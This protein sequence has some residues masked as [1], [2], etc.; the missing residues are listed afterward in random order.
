M[1]GSQ[2]NSNF[3]LRLHKAEVRFDRPIVADIE[4]TVAR[5]IKPALFGSRKNIAIAVGSRGIANIARIVK[6]TVRSL[7]DFGLSPFIIPAMGSHGGATAEGQAQVLASYGVTEREIGCPVR[8]S[9]EVLSLPSE[10]LPHALYMDRS[11]FEADGIVLINRIK[12]HTDFHGP[13]ESGLVKMSVIGLGK[14]L[15]AVAIH[16]FGVHGLRDLVPKAAARILDLGKIVAGIAI[17]ENAY[18]ETAQIELVPAN[19][20]LAREPALLEDA[21]KN[22]P[23]FPV[24]EIDVLIVDELGKNISG[25]GMDTNIIGRIYIPGEPEPS[26]PRIRSIIVDDVTS[27]SHGNATGLGLADV[28]T[29]R[30]YSKIDFPVTYR[31]I[32]TSS[33]LER[34]K[35]PVIA[36]TAREAFQIAMRSCG[37]IAPDTER[38]V[39]IRNTLQL[40]EIYVSSAIARHAGECP[41]DIDVS[42]NATELFTAKGDLVPFQ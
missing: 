38:V 19:Q 21:R 15:Q 6:Q 36:E 25:S 33:F 35:T 9:M 20:I 40:S 42:E 32:I 5:Q 2:M 18:D 22:M 27:E 17:V 10:G 26:T 13:Y 23:R 8:S 7:H 31:N 30:F 34:G 11:A 24:H 37:K 4:T 39:R 16:D 1:V 12:P 29:R 28:I 41:L 3:Q 14:E